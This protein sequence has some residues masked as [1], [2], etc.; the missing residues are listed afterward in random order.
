LPE[1]VNVQVLDRVALVTLRDPARRNAISQAMNE[2][3]LEILPEL[4][5][6]EDVGALVLTGVDPAF[7]AGA[8]LDA[9]RRAR[10]PDDFRQLY[11]GFLRVGAS[12]L[13]SL[14]AVNGPAVGAGMNLALACD[15]IIA[16]E[17]ARFDS[18]FLKIGIHPGGG[19][20]WRLS[21]RADDS[22]ARAMVL[23]GEVLD[24]RRA[25]EAGLAWR[26]VPD[27]ELVATALALARKASVV[28]RELVIRTKRTFDALVGVGSSDEA[29]E[30]EIGP[31]AWSAR[32]ESFLAMGRGDHGQERLSQLR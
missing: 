20:T 4:E 25:A 22:T 24:G 3:L 28:P 12:T 27:G 30:L 21:R 18:R 1:L 9:L 26:C 2:E 23:F 11:A 29:V 10:T 13:P 8:D 15:L 16:G 6:R 19:H 31:Q 5:M 32:Q 14:A 17:S 7:C